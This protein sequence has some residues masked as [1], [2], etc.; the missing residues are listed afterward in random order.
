WAKELA[1]QIPIGIYQGGVV[2]YPDG[3]FL[4][5]GA[6]SAQRCRRA[7]SQAL[8]VGAAPHI[9]QDDGVYVDQLPDPVREYFALLGVRVRPLAEALEAPVRKVGVEAE[10][11]VLDRLELALAAQ[12][13]ERWLRSSP[14]FLELWADGADK[15]RALAY[16]ADYL[17]VPQARTVAIGDGLNDLEMIQWAGLGIAMG[18]SAPALLACATRVTGTIEEDGAAAAIY[19]LL[20][21]G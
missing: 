12:G 7:I 15:G 2:C 19:R 20:A 13:E 9:H 18:N 3:R 8:A 5:K 10:A 16:L 21:E 17:G 1:V 14:G 6:V 4:Y 11:E